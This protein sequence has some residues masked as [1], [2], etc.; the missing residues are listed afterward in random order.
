MPGC[1]RPGETKLIDHPDV[2]VQ[3]TVVSHRPGIASPAGTRA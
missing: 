2:D 1:L 3:A